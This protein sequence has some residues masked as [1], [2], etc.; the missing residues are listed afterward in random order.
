MKALTFALCERLGR[1]KESAESGFFGVVGLLINRER[2]TGS[3]ATA[4]PET[5]AR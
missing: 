4:T 5:I 2:E 1:F 3:A